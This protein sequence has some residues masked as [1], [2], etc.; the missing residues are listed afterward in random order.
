[1]V[2]T[3]V[4]NNAL[5][6]RSSISLGL[7]VKAMKSDLESRSHKCQLPSYFYAFVGSM[8]LKLCS[9]RYLRITTVKPLEWGKV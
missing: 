7:G 4:N 3:S 8:I 2:L 1:V 9:L 6:L 5:W